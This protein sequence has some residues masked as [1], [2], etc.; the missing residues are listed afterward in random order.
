MRRD[1]QIPKFFNI[2]SILN[3]FITNHNKE[4]ECYLVNYDLKPIFNDEQCVHIKSE[5]EHNLTNFY[6]NR[7][8]LL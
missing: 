8:S 2:D 1:I 5:I 4:I 6:L 3:E 7:F